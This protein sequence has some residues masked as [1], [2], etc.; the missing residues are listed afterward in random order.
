MLNCC[1]L[2]DFQDLKWIPE[3]F[4]SFERAL[5]ILQEGASNLGNFSGEGGTTV[6]YSKNKIILT[7]K[8]IGILLQKCVYVLCNI[9]SLGFVTPGAYIK[10][11]QWR[12]QDFF[13]GVA[14][15]F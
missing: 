13:Q 7:W 5:K 15:F 8:I 3:T 6:K 12:F 14:R 4:Q 1:N 10:D 9:N 2:G 11:R